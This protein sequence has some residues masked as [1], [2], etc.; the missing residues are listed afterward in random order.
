[1]PHHP[2]LYHPQQKLQYLIFVEV[3]PEEFLD[4]VFEI[5]LREELI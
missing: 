5:L 1:M 2:G 3:T 4:E